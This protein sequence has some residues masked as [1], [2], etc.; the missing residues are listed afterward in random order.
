MKSKAVSADK[1]MEDLRL[2]VTDAEELLR[3]TA[4]QAGEKVAAA[5]ARAEESIDAAKA[6]IAQAGYAAAA[7]TREAAKAADDYVHDNPWT[8][9]GVAAAVGVV[10]GILIAKK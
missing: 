7:Q 2:V 4:G 8:A 3:A 10:I 1:L 5:R 6:R 9:V